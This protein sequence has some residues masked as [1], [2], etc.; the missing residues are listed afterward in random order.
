VPELWEANLTLAP[1][2]REWVCENPTENFD[3]DGFQVTPFDAPFIVTPADLIRSSVAYTN[4]AT[5]TTSAWACRSSHR[6][7]CS[8]RTKSGASSRSSAWKGL[9]RH[10]MGVDLGKICHIVVGAV[11][12]DGSMQVVHCERVESDEVEGQVQ[13]VAD[14]VPGACRR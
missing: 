8:H 13:G 1:D 7:P 9:S 5:S 3:A 6:S 10:V 2:H 11:A 14:T 4:V 12:Y